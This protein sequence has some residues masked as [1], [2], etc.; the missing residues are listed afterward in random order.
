MSAKKL[1]AIIAVFL[2]LMAAAQSVAPPPQPLHFIN[3]HW[4]P[5]DP[6]IEIGRAHV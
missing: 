1:F 4:T 6:P 2:P 5:Y 3:D